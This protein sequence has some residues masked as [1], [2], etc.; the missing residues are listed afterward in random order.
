[1]TKDETARL[2]AIRRNLTNQPH[3]DA[4]VDAWAAALAPWTFDQCRAAIIVAARTHPQQIAV[5][6]LIERLPARA[7]RRL[8]L[9]GSG[10]IDR[11]APR[12]DGPIPDP[13]VEVE[14]LRVELRK[15]RG[16]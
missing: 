4:T 12:R 11:D 7:T 8:F 3:N 13:V 2:L 6:N 16:R 5:G 14:R 15:T 9:V 1:M 10:Y